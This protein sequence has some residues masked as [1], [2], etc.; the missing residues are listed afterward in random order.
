MANDA[1]A[2]DDVD[3]DE[4]IRAVEHIFEQIMHAPGFNYYIL[5]IKQRRKH[6]EIM[7]SERNCFLY[8]MCTVVVYSIDLHCR[9]RHSAAAQGNAWTHCRR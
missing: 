8:V 5:G 1:V 4:Q 7:R 9:F 2:L 3:I 6:W